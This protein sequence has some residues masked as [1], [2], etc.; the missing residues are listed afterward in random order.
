MQ[1]FLSKLKMKLHCTLIT[2]RAIDK[3]FNQCTR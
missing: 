3:I 2:G 1:S